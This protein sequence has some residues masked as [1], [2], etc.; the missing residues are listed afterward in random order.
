[1]STARTT[2]KTAG[3]VDYPTAVTYLCWVD[4]YIIGPLVFCSV[5]TGLSE[6]LLD[7]LHD[8]REWWEGNP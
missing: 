8:H 1:M 5:A 7:D 4:I 6:A 2:N 3:Y